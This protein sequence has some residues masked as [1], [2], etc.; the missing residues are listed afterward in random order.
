MSTSC[1]VPSRALCVCTRS[2]MTSCLVSSRALCVCTRSYM[3]S[4]LVNSRALCVCTRSYMTSYLIPSRAFC[5]CTR[6][7]MTSC[8]IPS[9]ALCACTRSY[10][11]VTPTW[12]RGRGTTRSPRTLTATIASCHRYRVLTTRIYTQ[13]GTTVIFLRSNEIFWNAIPTKIKCYDLAPVA[14]VRV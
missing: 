6:S 9:R 11:S 12:T 1:L 14:E 7:Y 3:T 8:L 2:Y 13:L 10:R 4:C 5:V